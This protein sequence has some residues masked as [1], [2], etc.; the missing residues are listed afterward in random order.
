M[1]EGREIGNTE[2]VG[3][4]IAL[5]FDDGD[6]RLGKMREILLLLRLVVDLL[7]LVDHLARHILLLKVRDVVP[8]FIIT[9]AV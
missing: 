8:K 1:R 9:L 7:R 5:G 4:K 6:P 3:V 2:T